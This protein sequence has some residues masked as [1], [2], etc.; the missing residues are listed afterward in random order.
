MPH[1]AII[2]GNTVETIIV[3]DD[4]ETCEQALRCTLVEVT[5]ENPIGVGWTLT[6]EG[7]QPPVNQESNE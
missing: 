3:A 6:D 5:E 1:Y 4:K 7:W 2:T